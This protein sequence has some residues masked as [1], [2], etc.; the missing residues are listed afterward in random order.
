[1]SWN[2]FSFG[3]QDAFWPLLAAL[4]LMILWG[5]WT[6]RKD[7]RDLD[8]LGKQ[9]LVWSP[10]RV[11][12]RRAVKG[13]MA[14]A[15]LVLLFLGASRLQ[16]KPVPDQ[17]NMSGV[18]VMI[19]LDVSKS[20]LTQDILPNRLEAAKRALMKW[21]SGRQGDRVGVVIFAGEALV[22]VPLT[23]DLNAVSLV[24]AKADPDEVDLGGTDIGKGLQA[25]LESLGKVEDKKRGKAILLLTDGEITE[26]SAILPQV[27]E[28]SRQMNVPIV[29]VGM[30]TPQGR[31][32]P[33]GTA[34]WG[35]ATYK[36]DS[37]GAVHISRLDEDTLR[38]I[39]DTTQ[40]GYISGSSVENLDDIDS[41]LD[42]LQKTQM[43]GQGGMKREELSPRL[44]LGAAFSLFLASVL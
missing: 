16:G 26:G 37:S 36:R 32:I 25:A 21:L 43:K 15:A 44:A 1:M 30:G 14:M 7:R 18:D 11:W 10:F 27:L 42:K 19:V 17:L 4:F 28:R 2:V 12:T 41:T 38:H 34:F 9:N 33:D 31:P 20:M 29:A 23:L 40:G 39:A 13:G 35:E 5:L 6:L 3:N 22:Q 24:L 8:F